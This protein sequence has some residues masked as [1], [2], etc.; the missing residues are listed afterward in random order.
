MGILTEAYSGEALINASNSL[1][2]VYNAPLAMVK[3]TGKLI[4]SLLSG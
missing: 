1:V 3:G 2:E 4:N